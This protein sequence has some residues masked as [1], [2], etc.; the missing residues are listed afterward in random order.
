MPRILVTRAAPDAQETISRLEA[1]GIEGVAAPLLECAPLHTSLPDPRGLAALAVTS[2]N[3]LR[4]LAERGARAPYLGLQLFAVGERTAAAARAAGFGCVV[5]GGGTLAQLVEAIAAASP[6][7]PV[8]Y[9][10][11]RHQSGDLA[12]ELAPFGLA[13][14]TAKVY[15]MRAATALPPAIVDDLATEQFDAALFHSRRAAETFATLAGDRLDAGVKA[16]LG[17]LCLSEQ[18]AEPLIDAHFVRIGLAD[19][20]N[21]AAMMT[22]ALAFVRDQN[23][24]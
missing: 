5:D 1:I 8:F 6:A 2:A 19:Q 14:A 12:E 9:P 24:S 11:A 10:T 20:P 7:G 4:T 22:L 23:A 16:R 13:V 15:E 3:A 17:A 18:V 21:E